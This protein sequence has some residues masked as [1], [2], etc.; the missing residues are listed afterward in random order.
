MER[1]KKVAGK[2]SPVVWHWYG[3][4]RIN[5]S[6]NFKRLTNNAG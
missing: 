6:K 3:L 1:S 4:K 2:F 5:I